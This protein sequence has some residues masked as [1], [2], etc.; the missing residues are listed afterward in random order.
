MKKQL[1]YSTVEQKQNPPMRKQLTYSTVWQR[2]STNEKA[3]YVQYSV[4]RTK[5]ASEKA[6][7]YNMAE[8]KS[9]VRTRSLKS[10]QQS[11][12][13]KRQLTTL[14]KLT[15]NEKTAY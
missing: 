7:S 11:L 10:R 4:E 14:Y 12:P 1:T 15:V 5:S 13:K 6:L 2:K 9:A 8:T 3:A